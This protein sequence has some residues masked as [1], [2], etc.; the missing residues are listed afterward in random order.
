M[1]CVTNKT[2]FKLIAQLVLEHTLDKRKVN[3]SNPFWLKT[4][5]QVNGIVQF[6]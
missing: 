3:G 2:N 5:L 4:N 1:K 6:W